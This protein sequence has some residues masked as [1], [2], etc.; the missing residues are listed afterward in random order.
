MI[1]ELTSIK[2]TCLYISDIEKC[3]NFYHGIL[4]LP[5]VS[6][7][8]DRHIF[9][10]IGDALLLCFIPEATKKEGRF[11]AHFA[12][13]PQHI[14][15]EVP[16]EDYEKWKDLLPTR[17][18]EITHEHT[19]SKGFKSFYFNDPDNNVLELVVPGMWD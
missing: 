10:K 11:P 8:E 1:M 15:F 13:G 9:F 17:G 7:V 12:Y 6:A 16:K 4:N 14:A 2:E 18:V 5:V 3:K 19:W